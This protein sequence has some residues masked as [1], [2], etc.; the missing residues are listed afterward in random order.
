MW[1]VRTER[2][3][4]RTSAEASRQLPPRVTPRTSSCEAPRVKHVRASAPPDRAGSSSLQR[5]VSVGCVRTHSVA[6]EA[7]RIFLKRSIDA[8]DRY[9]FENRI[10]P[11]SDER[12]NPA[13]SRVLVA[14]ESSPAL[15]AALRQYSIDP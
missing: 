9:A 12:M 7:S 6:I 1:A 8:T 3:S 2:Q 15:T 4:R 10:A 14:A 13:S 5:A 11:W